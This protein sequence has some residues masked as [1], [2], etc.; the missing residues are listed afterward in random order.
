MSV[1]NKLISPCTSARIA[2]AQDEPICVT[3]Q[4][5]RKLHRQKLRDQFMPAGKCFKGD[6]RRDQRGWVQCW[7]CGYIFGMF[8]IHQLLHGW[9]FCSHTQHVSTKILCSVSGGCLLLSWTTSSHALR[10]T[11]GAVK[12]AAKEAVTERGNCTA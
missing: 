9:K 3:Q 6:L 4:Q 7:W 8:E 11:K 10:Q 12:A 2:L 5:E 1:L